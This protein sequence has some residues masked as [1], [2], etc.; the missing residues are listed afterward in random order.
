MGSRRVSLG[1]IANEFFDANVSTM[2]GF[3]WAARQVA[4]CFAG[5]PLLG[6]DV[7]LVS[8][9]S[10]GPGMPKEARSHGVP[11]LFRDWSRLAVLRRMRS[12]R[13]DLLLTIDY[14]PTYR[15]YLEAL[16]R[17]PVV[18][19]VRDP[20]PP[21]DWA[22]IASL[23][24]P[25]EVGVV[26]CGIQQVDCRSL[27]GIVRWSRLLR[28]RVRFATPA[29]YLAAK[30]EATYGTVPPEVTFLPNPIELDP[31]AAT[32]SGRP[33]VVF[34]GRLDPIKRP[35][36]FF[37]LARGFPDV[38][39]V[40][41]GQAHFDGCGSWTPQAIPPNVRAVGHVDG[42]AKTQVLA[43]AWVLVNTSIHE[44]LAVSFLE[45]LRCETPLL[46]LQDPGGL[47]S[48]FG[49]HAGECGGTG[50]EA[51]PRLSAGL[52]RLLGDHDLRRRLG[53]EGSRWVAQTHSGAHFLAAFRTLCGS[54]GVRW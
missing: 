41:L 10:P 25:G 27:A 48:R 20:R 14:R 46:A 49:I 33:R 26:P 7:T 42:T 21:E 19:W 24:I 40:V 31:G 23:R 29:P 43:S 45:A 8:G 35:W 39:F 3:G 53:R 17:T 38:E 15:V 52:D 5:D 2:G 9:L 51:L 50:L 47:V 6:V 30:M 32:K 12:R 36:L 44:A 34:L 28:R 1:I 11:I 13:F 54:L 16:P 4:R 37:E 18:V 22:E